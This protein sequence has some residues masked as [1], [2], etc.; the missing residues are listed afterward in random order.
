MVY[1]MIFTML[2]PLKPPSFLFDICQKWQREK[3]NDNT[4]LI[5]VSED[6]EHILITTLGLIS[7]HVSSSTIPCEVTYVLKIEF[8]M[9]QLIQNIML[10]S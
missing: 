2:F 1:W 7:R 10:T 3:Q 4:E 5:F 9:T 6:N 8:E